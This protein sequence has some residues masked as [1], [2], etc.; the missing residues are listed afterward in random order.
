MVFNS[1]LVLFYHNLAVLHGFLEPQGILC[2]FFSWDK[3]E[4]NKTLLL[5]YCI[6]FSSGF[7]NSEVL[8]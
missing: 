4:I 8:P 3:R 1:H 5:D 7:H 2:F 6:V